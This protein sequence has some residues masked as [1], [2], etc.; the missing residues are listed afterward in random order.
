[1]KISR[2]W[3]VVFMI[4][5]LLAFS[6]F[7]VSAK[8]NVVQLPFTDNI[9]SFV[10]YY[11]QSQ[12]ILAQGTLF[13]GL[14]GYAPDP[15]GLGG[16]KVVPVIADKWTCS[17]DG[18]TWTITLRKDKKWSN[19]D[20][21]T[22]RDFEWTY[23]Y[24]CDP[25][26]TDVPLWANHLQ[27]LKNGWAVKAGGVPVDELGVKAL[28]DYTLQFTLSD[29]KYDFNCWL[30]VG[31]AMPLHRKTVEKWGANWWKPEHF[32]GNGPYVPTSWTDHKEAV[33]VKNKYY[34]GTRGNVDKFVLKCFAAGTS[35]IQSYQSGELDLAWIYNV[36]DYKYAT[37]LAILKKAYHETPND[38][39]W[40][41][42]QLARGFNPVFD[43]IKVRQAF[44]MSIDRSLL[45]KTVLEGR[46]FPTGKYWMS[47]N[48][49]GSK[50][51]EIPFDPTKAKKL[52]AEAGYPGGKGLP[53][54]KF[55]MTVNMP[56]VEFIVD[57]WKKNLGVN[58]L[59]EN[60]ESGVY[61]NQYVW[62]NWTPNA[63]PGFTRMTAPMNS[64]EIGALLKGSD[65]TLWFYDL[66]A[67]VRKHEYE[68][69]N[70]RTNF[71][72]KEG[73][74]TATEWEPMLSLK[75]KL[76]AT[77]KVIIAKET[78][79]Y[80]LEDMTRKPMW[81]DQFDE[82]YENWKNAKTAKEKTEIWRQANRLLLDREKFQVEY[83]GMSEANKKARRILFEMRN[84]TF[85][86]AMELAPQC[87]QTIQ[88]Q[89][90]MVPLFVEKAQYVLRPNIT[91][92]MVYKFSWGP[93]VFNLKYINVK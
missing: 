22:A 51:K 65:H 76:L 33:L 37:K 77:D 90:Y 10:P 40:S 34:V 25:S 41:G 38:L 71:L 85:E 13:E 81:Q 68:L 69:E 78:N 91:G 66:P 18:K 54:L 93:Q 89:Y 70:E 8:E 6:I 7:G 24:A 43:N 75:E 17:E 48:T 2:T 52:L 3:L 60:L 74:V 21:I 59:I 87:L 32:V 67:S 82:M 73:G 56:E 1:M 28:D 53:Q 45:T 57:Q 30:V 35:L 29:A 46:S 92:L 36:A 44:A 49:I 9:P 27:Y 11:W 63:E 72:T 80:W 58:V 84:S 83:N 20:P 64:F 15:K 4:C 86:K 5:A 50:L 61:G 55:Y 39:F 62:A 16:I 19:G 88:D 12:H 23:K 47:N 79:K 26:L 14:F 31:G 42:Y